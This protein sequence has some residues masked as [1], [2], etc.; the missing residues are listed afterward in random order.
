MDPVA[1]LTD[2]SNK[3]ARIIPDN[4]KNVTAILQKDE[5]RRDFKPQDLT[6]F[7]VASPKTRVT[8][9]PMFGN[10]S[11]N[12][13]IKA[14]GME[15]GTLLSW[16]ALYHFLT[17]RGTRFKYNKIPDVVYSENYTT[18]RG[19]LE[20]KIPKNVNMPDPFE[21][22]AYSTQL[23]KLF[24]DHHDNR[25]AYHDSGLQAKLLDGLPMPRIS[26]PQ[27]DKVDIMLNIQSFC[28]KIS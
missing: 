9:L 10:H 16:H 13:K 11:D 20:V 21:P 6:R 25:K 18:S 24:R 12:T 5:R 26:E 19:K 1:G 27:I 4:V 28:E 3:D 8:L 15:S 14:E 17:Q 2:K 23:L 22:I 7:I